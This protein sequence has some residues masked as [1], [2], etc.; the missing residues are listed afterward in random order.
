MFR[1]MI[2]N[3]DDRIDADYLIKYLNNNFVKQ[4][5]VDRIF[6]ATNDMTLTEK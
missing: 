2:K 3:A 4:N 5:E 6:N 1:M